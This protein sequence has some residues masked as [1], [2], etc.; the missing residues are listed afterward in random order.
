MEKNCSKNTVALSN[1][2]RS[3]LNEKN[4][5]ANLTLMSQ[6]HFLT[7]S[8]LSLAH[9]LIFHNIFYLTDCCTLIYL[10]FQTNQVSFYLV[11]LQVLNINDKS[12]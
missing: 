7:P 1:N 8:S 4:R 5:G 3:F 2:A 6:F 10:L 12:I 11:H 9:P